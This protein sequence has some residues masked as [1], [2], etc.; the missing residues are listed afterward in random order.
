MT[1]N[2]SKRTDPGFGKDP[3]VLIYDGLPMAVG[4]NTALAAL[5]VTVLWTVV[6]PLVAGSWLSLVVAAQAGRLGLWWHR[7]RDQDLEPNGASKWLTRFRL[8]AIGTGG[9]WGAAAWML[10]P[11]DALM[12]Q[13]FL[14]FVLAGLTAGAL[15]SLAP[16]RASLLGFVG[17]ALSPLALRFLAQGSAMHLV[18]ATMLLL[19]MAFIASSAGR[20]RSLMTENFALARHAEEKAG[21]SLRYS[22][23]QKVVGESATRLL[24]AD[25]KTVDAAI[26]ESLAQAGRLLGVDRA[27]L[28]LRSD[29]GTHV[30]NTHEWSAPGVAPQKEELQDIPVAIA[31]WWWRKMDDGEMLAIPDVATMPPEAAQEQAVFESLGLRA[32]CAFPVRVGT[33]TAGFI[34]F[35]DVSGP[36]DWS[37]QAVELL[38][39]MAHLVGSALGRIAGERALDA[40]R[41]LLQATLESGGSGVLAVDAEGGVLFANGR[42]H[43]MWGLPHDLATD[44]V[45]RDEDLLASV[46]NLLTDPG[47]FRERVRSLYRS[48]E[49]SEELINLVDGRVFHRHSRPLWD[50]GGLAGRVWTFYDVTERVDSERRAHVASERLNLAQRFAAIGTYEWDIPSGHVI[51]TESVYALLGYRDGDFV[52][53]FDRF[54]ALVHPDDRQEVENAVTRSIEADVPY[55]LEHRVV[56]PDG[57]SRWLLSQGNVV[58]NPQG[59]PTR[60]LGVTQDIDHQKRV[61]LALANRERQ[62]LEAQALASLGHWEANL[63]TGELA[64][65]PEIFRIFGRDPVTFTPTVDAF[66]ASVHPDDRELVLERERRAQETN[67]LDV[68][69]R[70]VRPDGAVRH[71]HE[72][73]RMEVDARGNPVRLLGTVQDVTH[74]ALAEEALLNQSRF[75][76]LVAEVAGHFVSVSAETLPE[77]IDTVLESLGRFFDVDR[78]DVLF[79][80]HDG[81]RLAEVYDWCREG[82]ESKVEALDGFSILD[83]PWYARQ[84]IQE[85]AVVHIPDLEELPPEAAQEKALLEE[86]G[87]KSALS[88]PVQTAARVLGCLGFDATRH[89]KRWSDQEIAGLSVLA[90]VL[91]STVERIAAD[92]A[93]R[94]ATARLALATRNVNLGMWEYDLARDHLVWN[95]EMHALT[96]VAPEAFNPT[97]ATWD[98]LLHPDD[99]MRTARGVEA[100]RKGALDRRPHPGPAHELAEGRSLDATFRIVR[101][102]SGETRWMRGA[103]TII[104]DERGV[105]SHMAGTVLDITELVRAREDA[106]RANRTKSDFLTSM[107]HELRTPLNAIL[108][109]GQFLEY[110]ET[111]SGEQRENVQEILRGGDHLLALINEVLDLARVESGVVELSLEPVAV[112]DVLEECIALMAP[113]GRE[114]GIGIT[115][116]GILQ[117][118]V[119]ADRTR[120]RQVLFNLLSN[121]VKYNREGGT[122]RVLVNASGPESLRILVRDTGVGIAPD[123]LDELLQPFNRLGAETGSIE[124]TGIGLTLTRHLTEAMGGTMGVESRVGVGSTFWVELPREADQAPDHE[125]P[126]TSGKEFGAG[127]SGNAASHTALYIEDNRANIKLVTQ[128]LK[129]IPGL[130]LLTAVTPEMGIESARAHGPELILL[131][132][133]LPGMHGF[134][135]LEILKS[136]PTLRATPVIALTANAMPRDVERGLAAGFVAY[137]TKPLDIEHF[138]NTVRLSLDGETA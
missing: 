116:Q 125:V 27:Y 94:S 26:E 51:W 120:L 37:G 104:V 29:A 36:R 76:S 23:V 61:R 122:V 30:S 89:G 1:P 97:Y 8:G 77:T 41:H 73:A 136:D 112:C 28:M 105:P 6:D 121:A 109:F 133:N 90:Q 46:E 17:L 49:G 66:H 65:S 53:S 45:T 70:I 72:L 22:E 78:C 35:D 38:G 56:W 3:L 95:Q 62:L 32:L 10:F 67:E 127:D 16:D 13:A 87:V 18:M 50:D 15:A 69:H 103:G 81:S 86:I 21:E 102:D 114:R 131:D 119:R 12:Y 124:G 2:V 118:S 31:P 84:I 63:V 91:A 58:R 79:L 40:N 96:G 128:V 100:A 75:Q 135:V 92:E 80:S 33:K 88:V 59:E 57:T 82:V 25:S 123:R 43:E 14:A 4:T 48:A 106:E 99:R 134:E 60:F 52:P 137:L 83:A 126:A 7:R 101:A 68:I 111:L 108:G 11:A 39:L 138:L 42:F 19:Y 117:A 132:L 93:T 55:E 85:R 113:L 5:L 24:A 74:R 64:W 44:G 54:L 20:L 110:D 129:R 71:V 98:S 130:H 107:S 115:H 47:G 34:G 9:L